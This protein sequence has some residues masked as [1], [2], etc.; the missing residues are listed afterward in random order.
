MQQNTTYLRL[1]SV[2]IVLSSLF[3]SG[4]SLMP[5][6]ML[7]DHKIQLN[8]KSS[9][10]LNPDVSDNPSPLTIKV[11]E[12][13]SPDAFLAAD[14]ITLFIDPKKILGNDLL[15]P[16]QIIQMTPKYKTAVIFKVKRQTQYLGVVAA[17]QNIQAAEW[18]LLIPLNSNWGSESRWIRA[19]KLSIVEEN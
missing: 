16:E 12:L 8:I 3:L 14:F 9:A 10:N 4:C 18:R 7:P 19:N 11:Y 6:A 13:N 15:G 2:W 17:Y 1:F 5:E